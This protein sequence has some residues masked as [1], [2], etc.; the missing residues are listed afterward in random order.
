MNEGKQEE[1]VGQASS[2]LDDLTVDQ[3]FRILFGNWKVLVLIPLS[4]SFFAYCGALFVRPTYT[5]TTTFMV[6]QQQQSAAASVLQNLG[7]LGGVAGAAAGIKNPADQYISFLRSRSLGK[8][9]IDRFDLK[10]KYSAKLTDDAILIL[11]RNALVY[12]GK[13]GII[14]VDVTDQDPKFAADMANAYVEELGRLMTRLAITEA[15]Q[16][17]SFFE[18]LLNQA[19][20]NMEKAESELKS[21]GIDISA[22][23]VN[24]VISV[25]SLAQ[26]QAQVTA[27]EIRLSALSGFATKNSPEYKMVTNEVQALRAQLH[28]ISTSEVTTEKNENGYLD[29]YRDLKYQETLFELYARQYEL[30]RADEAKDGVVIQVVDYADVPEKKS[31]PKKLKIAILAGVV[32]AFG[33]L[34]YVFV[35]HALRRQ[36]QRVASFKE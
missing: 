33:A 34:I 25:G 9:M 11:E 19:K 28:R 16:R 18:K 17:R 4:L 3:L 22:L 31:G 13:D 15:Q 10:K 24:P 23:R 8:A 30:A 20:I 29:K 27:A 26:L 7:V 35:R 21:T 32:C 14:G 5:A 1:F 12:T 2:A 6:P 36:S